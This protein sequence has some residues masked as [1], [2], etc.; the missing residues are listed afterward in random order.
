MA[1]GLELV[2]ERRQV[3]DNRPQKEREVHD[4]GEHILLFENFF[5]DEFI[6]SCIDDFE[7]AEEAG[8][9]VSRQ[10]HHSG[11]SPLSIEDKALPWTMMPA[12]SLPRIQELQDIMTHEIIPEFLKKYPIA[13]QYR[14][15]INLGGAKLQKTAPT[16][17][18]HVWHMEHSSDQ[19]SYRSICAWALLL[20]D[21]EEGGELE[22]LY[23]S[24]RIRPRRGE[25][26]LWPAGYTHQHR[27]NPP[28]KGNKY[29]FTGWLDTL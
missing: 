21:V 1:S 24:Q 3:R 19:N 5:S 17:G 10:Q 7:L 23:Q 15:G 9:T 12:S 25:F 20:N 11:P 22:F 13:E 14:Y 27:G 16:Q 6:D 26:V 8:M 29:I 2:M 28:L 18:Y 4:L